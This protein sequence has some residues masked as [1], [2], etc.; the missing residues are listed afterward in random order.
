MYHLWSLKHTLVLLEQIMFTYG[1]SQKV[2]SKTK[3]FHLVSYL[4]LYM[5]L[6][7]PILEVFFQ[8]PEYSSM[9]TS[10]FS[11][12]PTQKS[13][14]L[15]LINSISLDMFQKNKKLVNMRVNHMSGPLLPL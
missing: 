15:I 4:E 3:H 10:I 13:G 5:L 11:C 8:V 14:Y 6:L 1:S 9:E 2:V 7:F 12:Y